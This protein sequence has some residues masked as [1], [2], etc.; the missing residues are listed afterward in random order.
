MLREI[1]WEQW[2][3][4]KAFSI[5]EPFDNDRE[6][7]LFG[8]IVQVIANVNRN[9]KKRQRPYSIEEA[10]TTFGDHDPRSLRMT[11]KK[12]LPTGK[13][14]ASGNGAIPHSLPGRAAWQDMKAM[15]KAMTLISQEKKPSD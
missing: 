15:A 12:A 13:K 14:K 10:M 11:P 2:E 7:A 4:W 9:P 3:E 5:V 1:T 8:Q 6:E